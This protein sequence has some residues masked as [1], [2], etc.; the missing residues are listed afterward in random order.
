M[1]QKL[2]A[3]SSNTSPSGSTAHLDELE[4]MLLAGV[5]EE[6]ES[7]SDVSN[8]PSPVLKVHYAYAS[9]AE[10]NF[11]VIRILG[12]MSFLSLVIFLLF[13]D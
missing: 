4:I 2:Q 3:H 13:V 6:D 5:N 7:G 10:F 1:L 9:R 12:G 8:L 11:W